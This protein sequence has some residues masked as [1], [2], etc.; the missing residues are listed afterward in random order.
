MERKEVG[1]YIIDRTISSYD[2]KIKHGIHKK[3]G[4]QV[5][6]RVYDKHSFDSNIDKYIEI[7]QN[8][9]IFSL[10]DH[11]HI[12]KLI[13]VFETSRELYVVVEY[14]SNGDMLDFLIQKE[15]LSVQESL[16]FFRELI[17]GLDYLQNHHQVYYD[18]LSL[19]H[20]LLDEFEHVKLNI[21]NSRQ[22]NKP[23]PLE[24]NDSWPNYASPELIRGQASSQDP[25][26]QIV[27]AC[28]VILYTFLTVCF[29][30]Y[31]IFAYHFLI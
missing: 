19:D 4:N 6:I 20:I 8:L 27:W 26:S 5:I 10:L 7:R 21:F 14:A 17:Y 12:L 24:E 28:G 15:K 25:E 13:E 22:L 2:R 18:T 3:S 9:A 1:D 30:I 29:F 31:F 16:K 23:N 11:P